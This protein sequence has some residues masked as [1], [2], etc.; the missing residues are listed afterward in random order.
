MGLSLGMSTTAEGVETAAQLDI[1]R[2]EGCREVQG[3]LFSAP[4]PASEIG[5]MLDVAAREDA[6]LPPSLI[7]AA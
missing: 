2:A 5:R 6:N 7:S 1:V 4:K 3:Y